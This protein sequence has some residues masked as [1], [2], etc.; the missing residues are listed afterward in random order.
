MSRYLIKIDEE[1][2]VEADNKEQAEQKF[3]KDTVWY[4]NRN[5]ESFIAVMLEVEKLGD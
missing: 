3:F 2:E 5:P 1:F 4:G